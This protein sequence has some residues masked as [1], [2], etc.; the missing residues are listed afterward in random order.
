MAREA[1]EELLALLVR[2]ATAAELPE[3]LVEGSR[4]LGQALQVGRLAV[5]GVGIPAAGSL[6][7]GA[8][9]TATRVGLDG[10]GVIPGAVPAEALLEAIEQARDR[11]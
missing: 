10:D 11:S 9:L 4:Q 3:H 5:L 7:T 1:V 2:E 6:G 8:G